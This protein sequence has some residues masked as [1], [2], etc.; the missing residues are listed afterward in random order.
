MANSTDREKLQALLD[1]K[2]LVEIHA[3]RENGYG[4]YLDKKT[5][6]LRFTPDNTQIKD[7]TCIYG[8]RANLGGTSIDNYE[9][10]EEPKWYENIPEQGVLCR[11][12]DKSTQDA[13]IK[14]VIEYEATNSPYCYKTID[15]DEYYSYAEPVQLADLEPY[16]LKEIL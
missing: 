11:V 4:I 7:N 2:V 16:I 13:A 10:R 5:D 6:Q 15:D 12:Y 14:I 3:A 8:V 9:I 1:G